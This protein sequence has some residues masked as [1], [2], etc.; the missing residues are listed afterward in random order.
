MTIFSN[1]SLERRLQQ[2]LQINEIT[3]QRGRNNGR[4]TLARIQAEFA[5]VLEMLAGF[6]LL[7]GEDILIRFVGIESNND[8][9]LVSKINDILWSRIAIDVTHD[10]N[11]PAPIKTEFHK[12]I[13]R[14]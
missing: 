10:H 14:P 8:L 7:V 12:S 9:R 13:L 5:H 4:S 11:R 2:A 6:I 3:K 1:K